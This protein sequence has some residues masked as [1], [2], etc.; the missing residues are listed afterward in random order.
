LT[1]GIEFIELV[2]FSRNDFEI[3]QEGDVV[4]LFNFVVRKSTNNQYFTRLNNAGIFLDMNS[5]SK[6]TEGVSDIES[7]DVTEV[8]ESLLKCPKERKLINIKGLV[9]LKS[10]NSKE[11][12]NVQ[13]L[14]VI[15]YHNMCS[16]DLLLY[17]YDYDF[18]HD[19]HYWLKNVVLNNCKLLVLNKF[20]ASEFTKIDGFKNETKDGNINDL[21]Y[22]SDI[23]YTF[24]IWEDTTASINSKGQIIGNVFKLAYIVT[25]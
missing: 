9:K 25:N 19:C 5:T 21:T 4:I 15:N 7:V 16:I 10:T 8:H 12:N 13:K 14:C 20:W 2:Q 22:Q 6:I 17:N 18:E 11:D 3:Y 24:E 23:Y 1:D